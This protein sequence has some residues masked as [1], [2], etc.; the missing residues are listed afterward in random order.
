MIVYVR[1]LDIVMK[2]VMKK[3]RYTIYHHAQPEQ[4]IN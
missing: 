4:M 2:D 1:E 3:I